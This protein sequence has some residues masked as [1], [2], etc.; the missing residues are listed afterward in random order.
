MDKTIKVSSETYRRIKKEAQ[1]N[2]CTLKGFVRILY[3]N[4]S[5]KKGGGYGR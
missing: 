4:Y 3:D 5:K 2:G 1:R